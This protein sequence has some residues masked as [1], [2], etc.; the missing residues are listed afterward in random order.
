MSVSI[1]SRLTLSTRNTDGTHAAAARGMRLLLVLAACGSSS[2]PAKPA[3]EP[4]KP[5]AAPA[6]DAAKSDDHGSIKISIKPVQHKLDALA[7]RCALVGDPLANAGCHNGSIATDTKG[8]IFVVDG[9]HV[10]RYVRAGEPGECRLELDAAFG[11]HGVAPTPPDNPRPQSLDGPVYMRSGGPD[12]R[13]VASGDTIYVHDYLGGLYRIDRGKPEKVCPNLFGFSTLAVVKGKLLIAR[14][15]IEQVALPSC[16]AKS[17]KLD[18]HAHGSIFSVHDQLYIADGTTV[19]RFEG[20]TAQ[21]LDAGELCYAD[22]I[23]TCGSGVCIVDHNCP[24]VIVVGDTAKKLDADDLFTN[25]PYGL[26]SAATAPDGTV[27]LYALHKEQ[28]MDAPCEGAVYAL[29]PAAPTDA[30]SPHPTRTP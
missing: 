15:G 24:S 4:A 26:G 17:A 30:S 9:A 14:K 28:G 13:V 2:E 11:D 6:P 23:T 1:G 21:K 18:D 7:K 16:K 25:R 5:V 12:W 10:R 8:G 20:A 27:Y 3:P 29:N 19:S 22:G